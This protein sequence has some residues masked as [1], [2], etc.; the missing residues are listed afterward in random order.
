MDNLSV[1][2]DIKSQNSFKSINTNKLNN[3]SNESSHLIGILSSLNISLKNSNDFEAFKIL[4]SFIENYF[5]EFE[6]VLQNLKKI[7]R[8]YIL[9]VSQDYEKFIKIKVDDLDF[10][11]NSILCI[12]TEVSGKVKYFLSKYIKKIVILAKKV[13][14]DFFENLMTG[15]EEMENSNYEFHKTNINSLIFD[16]EVFLLN[17]SLFYNIKLS[18]ESINLLCSILKSFDFEGIKYTLEIIYFIYL[19]NLD[20][21]YKNESNNKVIELFNTYLVDINVSET[22]NYLQ[23]N[24][25]SQNTNDDYF[26]KVKILI[27]KIYSNLY[28]R[29]QMEKELSDFL[30][31]ENDTFINIDKLKIIPSIISNTFDNMEL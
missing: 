29:R 4:N 14:L 13:D 8:R 27:N 24:E 2:N 5:E 23:F 17:H 12:F 15:F 16:S 31:N 21:N 11:I 26:E 30:S 20:F 6:I 7:D 22:N 19:T 18:N 28:K 25:I 3:Q 1:E 9:S 10:M